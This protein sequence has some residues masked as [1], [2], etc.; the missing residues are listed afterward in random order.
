MK[1]MRRAIRSARAV[2]HGPKILEFLGTRD[3]RHALAV[4]AKAGVPPVTA[5]STALIKEIGADD[6]G[7]IRVKQFVGVCVRAILEEE[8]FEVAAKGVRVSNDPV[9]RTGTTYQLPRS[10]SARSS[11]LER[12]IRSL[13]DEEAKEAVDLL[14]RRRL[15]NTK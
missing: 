10:I 2:T 11:F 4:A 15:N 13:T 8:G 14:R 6:A 1:T 3:N 9:F 7:Q 5:I 12:V